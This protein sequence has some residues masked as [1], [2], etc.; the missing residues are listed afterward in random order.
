MRKRIPHYGHYMTA[1]ET[2]AADGAKLYHSRRCAATGME[3][4]TLARSARVR[5]PVIYG[6]LTHEE[7]PVR[8]LLL[9]DW[10]RRAGRGA[11]AHSKR[12]EQLKDQDCRSDC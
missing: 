6:V 1:V 11:G 5:M 7:H 8:M 4:L 9:N 2:D 10:V 3:N 12:W